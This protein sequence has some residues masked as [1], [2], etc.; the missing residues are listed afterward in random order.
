MKYARLKPFCILFEFLLGVDASSIIESNR[1]IHP[2]DTIH[3]LK[4]NIFA[5]T[6]ISESSRWFGFFDDII[7]LE[8]LNKV[9]DDCPPSTSDSKIL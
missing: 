1:Q 2:V 9:G 7:K 6:N 8:P 3:K 5:G 4:I